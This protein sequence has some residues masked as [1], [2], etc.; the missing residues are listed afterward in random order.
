MKKGEL[1]NVQNQI[2]YANTQLIKKKKKSKDEYD[3]SST[4]KDFLSKSAFTNP[5]L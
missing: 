3:Y 1:K 2:I 4:P 5:S